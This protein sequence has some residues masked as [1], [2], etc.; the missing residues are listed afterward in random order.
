MIS[1]TLRHFEVIIKN[2][3]FKFY[4]NEKHFSF[5]FHNFTMLQP[6]I[7]IYRNNLSTIVIGENLISIIVIAQN[8]VTIRNLFRGHVLLFDQKKLSSEDAKKWPNV[9]LFGIMN[10]ENMSHHFSTKIL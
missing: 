4:E 10:S 2:N 8:R 1:S 5:L 3:N 7:F 9:L 6:E